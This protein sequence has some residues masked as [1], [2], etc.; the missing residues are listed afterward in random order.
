LAFATACFVGCG[1]PTPSPKPV[2]SPPDASPASQPQAKGK[3]KG[4]KIDP[5]ANM[6]RDEIRAYRKQQRE[7]GKVQ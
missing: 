7:Q 6:D 2:A 1:E 5:T 4:K 3:T